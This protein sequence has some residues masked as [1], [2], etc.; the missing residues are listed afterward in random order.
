MAAQ[1]LRREKSADALRSI[2]EAAAELGLQ[3]H[4]LR[5]WEGK[6]PKHVKPIKRGDGRR[7]FRPQDVEALR[8]IQLLV[9]TRGM[10]LKGAKA[11]LLEQGVQAVLS[12]DARLTV[13]PAAA[14][15]AKIGQNHELD[16]EPVASPARDL[17]A[18]VSAAFDAEP[19]TPIAAGDA[20]SKE[21]LQNVL[22]EMT[23]LKRRIEA[24]R[25]ARAA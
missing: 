5:Y 9:H 20:G 15:A 18:K 11:L 21:R 12:G 4:V 6:F 24:K 7:M 8:A 3:T 23:D 2:G 22:V 25:A 17:Q 1:K 10:T 19:R 13:A 14:E 16:L